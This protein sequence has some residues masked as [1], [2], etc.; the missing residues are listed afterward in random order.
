M[1]RMELT[2]EDRARVEMEARRRERQ[3]ANGGMDSHVARDM[4]PLTEEELVRRLGTILDRVDREGT[5]GHAVSTLLDWIRHGGILSEEANRLR[6]ELTAL[7]GYYDTVRAKL[8]RERARVGTR[9]SPNTSTGSKPTGST[10]PTG[11]DP[12]DRGV[13]VIYVPDGAK[14][15]VLCPAPKGTDAR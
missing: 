10:S 6:T 11:I 3:K 4:V 14:V 9:T 1:C 13:Q 8:K 7:R 2:I 12:S 15:M 5:T